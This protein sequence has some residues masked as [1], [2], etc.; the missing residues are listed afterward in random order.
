MQAQCLVSHEPYRCT[1]M[2]CKYV[3]T[4]CAAQPPPSTGRRRMCTLGAGGGGAPVGAPLP[5]APGAPSWVLQAAAAHDK[6]PTAMLCA[7]CATATSTATLRCCGRWAPWRGPT[8]SPLSRLLL[9]PSGRA[10]R[11]SSPQSWGGGPRRMV[12][13][14]SNAATSSRPG[15]AGSAGSAGRRCSPSAEPAVPAACAA[16]PAAAAWQSSR[17]SRCC[18]TR[19]PTPVTLQARHGPAAPLPGCCCCCCAAVV[20]ATPGD[21][22]CAQQPAPNT[23]ASPTRPSVFSTMPPLLTPAATL[24]SGESATQPTVS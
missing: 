12:R 5:W 13:C 19:S 22:S 15:S 2:P 11:Q 4:G 16:L 21:P 14:S 1:V 3:C 6:W 9:Q 17:A 18:I 8:L 7:L 24:P 20:G 10:R 23:A